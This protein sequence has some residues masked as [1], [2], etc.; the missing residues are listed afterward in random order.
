[1]AEFF[2]HC[3]FSKNSMY[4]RIEPV[5]S[6]YK[7]KFTSHIRL[8]NLSQS[9]MTIYTRFTISNVRGAQNKNELRF[10][11]R[12]ERQRVFRSNRNDDFPANA[13]LTIFATSA[14]IDV[15]PLF[16]F[17]HELRWTR[18]NRMFVFTLRI[19]LLL[20]PFQ[21]ALR[22][23]WIYLFNLLLVIRIISSLIKEV[24]DLKWTLFN[25]NFLVKLSIRCSFFNYM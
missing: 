6:F 17:Q 5:N 11:R 25:S 7:I 13:S 3:R 15:V 16:L 21:S 10:T 12:N 2:F 1:M 9:V 4:F 20:T 24:I 22:T 18:S 14:T 8:E 23:L 19:K